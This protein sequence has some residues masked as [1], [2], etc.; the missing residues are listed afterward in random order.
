[1]NEYFR[2]IA[3]WTAH[4]VGTPWSFMAACVF[5]VAWIATG[6]IYGY[7]DTWQLVMNTATS[8]LTFLIVFLI[9]NSQNRDTRVLQ[10]KLDELIR[11][12]NNAR[13]NFIDLEQ[14]SDRQLEQLQ[15]EFQRLRRGVL[16]GRAGD[17]GVEESE[18]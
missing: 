3:Q 11:S 4:A 5:V 18:R 10:L 16:A 12:V 9:Q 17:N 6:P 15:Q 8:V 2:A 14:L 1:M 13:N 7:S